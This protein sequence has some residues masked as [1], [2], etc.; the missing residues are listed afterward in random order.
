MTEP[1][2][3]S[4]RIKFVA[5]SAALLTAALALSYLE[6]LIPV[7]FPWLPGFK[8]GLANIAVVIAFY[9]LSPMAS[10]AIAVLKSV[11]TSLLFSGVTSLAFSLTGTV[12]A[13]LILLLLSTTLRG[14]IGFVGLS[15]S[16]A[17]FHNLG[18]LVAAVVVMK[19]TA[20]LYY[21]PHLI[22]AALIF[23]A[24]CGI[25]LTFLPGRIYT[26]KATTT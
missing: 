17:L 16:M 10:L 7:P 4:R 12:A 19:S 22:A 2:L 3:S 14:R 15:I 20:A 8:I 25:I 26:R 5:E 13:Y 11:I 23:G 6:V 1:T 21:L 18:Q 24:F 9:R